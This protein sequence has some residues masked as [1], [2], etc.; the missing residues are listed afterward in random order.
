[1]IMGRD[2][3]DSISRLFRLALKSPRGKDWGKHCSPQGQ[4][5]PRRKRWAKLPRLQPSPTELGVKLPKYRE[6]SLHFS[7]P[8][9]PSY[10]TSDGTEKPTPLACHDGFRQNHCCGM[11]YI[12]QKSSLDHITSARERLL[13]FPDL[14]FK[15]QIRC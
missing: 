2:P 5:H 8:Q 7:C 13:S 1:M 6:G 10:A 11:S 4:F 12:Q 14:T 3:R 9:P 15:I